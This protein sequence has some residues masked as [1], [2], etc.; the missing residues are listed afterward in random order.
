MADANIVCETLPSCSVES[1]MYVA[2]AKER[3]SVFSMSTLAF[4]DLKF[5]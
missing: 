1:F 4:E 5:K 2:P 3:I